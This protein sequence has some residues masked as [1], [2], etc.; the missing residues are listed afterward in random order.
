MTENLNQ[1]NELSGLS[2]AKRAV[3]LSFNFLLIILAYYQVKSASRSL[4]IEYGGADLF[5]HVWITSAIVLGI[6]IGFYHR[7]ALRN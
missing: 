4:L 5:P 7:I 6:F 3:I 2:P 1:N